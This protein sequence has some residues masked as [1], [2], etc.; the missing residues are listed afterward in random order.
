M[1][2][3]DLA[4]QI[5]VQRTNPTPDTQQ[6]GFTCPHVQQT[7]GVEDPVGD[8]LQHAKLYQD[9]AIEYKCL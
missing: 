6:Q 3:Q 2:P 5:T 9:A 1:P 7:V 8:I 4:S